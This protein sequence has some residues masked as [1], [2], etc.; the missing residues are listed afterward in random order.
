LH[1]EVV[2]AHGD[3]ID[4]DAAMQ[5]GVDGD[6]QLGADA[7][8]RGDQNG[9]AETRGFEIEERAEAAQPAGYAR[10]ARG[11]RR[12][13]DP[14]DEASACVDIHAGLGIGQGLAVLWHCR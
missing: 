2:D 4:A 8:G 3:Q 5:A 9:I 12:R 13:L 14:L 1:D 11:G 10:A 7:V 6:L